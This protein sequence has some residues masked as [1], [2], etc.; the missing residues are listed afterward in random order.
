VPASDDHLAPTISAAELQEIVRVFADSDLRELRISVGGT[1]LLVSRNEQV[2]APAPAAAPPPR[3]APPSSVLAPGAPAAPAAPAA[4]PGVAPRDEAAAAGPGPESWVAV[5]SPALGTFY[6][7]P[8]PG[9]PP[10]V[11]VGDTVGVGDPV[12]TIEV[13]KMFTTVTAD[14]A[15]TVVEILAE[16]ATLIEHGQTVLYVE[17]T[18]A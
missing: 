11:E 1:E 16:D 13:M 7:R 6:R 18:P 15:G 10:F 9:Q 5:A 14:V 4:A 8:G 3:P 17:P 2:E 12:G